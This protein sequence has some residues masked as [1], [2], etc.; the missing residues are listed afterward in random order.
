MILLTELWERTSAKNKRYFAG[1][2]AKAKVVMFEDGPHPDR[3]G[4]TIWKLFVAENEPQ[5]QQRDQ[6]PRRDQPARSRSTWNATRHAARTKAAAA[7]QAILEQAGRR[8][9]PSDGR[10][11]DDE[12]PW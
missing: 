4:V 8:A 11:F 3:P 12:I 5:Q 9:E 7:G 6:A 2:L 1:Y 10:P